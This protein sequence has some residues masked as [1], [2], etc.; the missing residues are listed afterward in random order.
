MPRMRLCLSLRVRAPR[1]DG[2]PGRALLPCGL[3]LLLSACLPSKFDDAVRAEE[4]T[5]DDAGAGV[6]ARTDAGSAP[7][8]G[9]SEPDAGVD[10]GADGGDELDHDVVD[11]GIVA[12]PDGAVKKLSGVRITSALPSALV[13]ESKSAILV[14]TSPLRLWMVRDEGDPA[15]AGQRWNVWEWL[16]PD[17]AVPLY[18]I[19]SALG[20]DFCFDKSYTLG[21][22][23]GAVVYLYDC[24]RALN[25]LWRPRRFDDGTYAFIN[26][27]DGRC[28][29]VRNA[30]A[31][32]GTQLQVYPC[33]F[34]LNQRFRVEG[35]D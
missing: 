23:D 19:E 5:P 17:D 13:I 10:A 18:A 1:C 26:K 12:T 9:P 29:D 25:Q 2:S 28:L 16:S 35:L 34:D 21:N 20:A 31:R 3:A 24:G 7:P 8:E 30:V 15:A 4:E 6:T 32:P 27:L 22:I 14:N 33:E 11:S